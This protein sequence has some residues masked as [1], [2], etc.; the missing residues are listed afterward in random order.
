[1]VS[2]IGR[3]AIG[4]VLVILF[5]GATVLPAVGTLK[6]N[7]PAEEKF[8]SYDKYNEIVPGEFIVKF[9][10]KGMVDSPAISALNEEHQVYSVKKI[11]KNAEDTILEHLYVLKV[12]KDSD[13]VSIVDDYS[14]CPDVV[15]AEPSVKV[16][17]C[18]IP[19]D[20]NFPYQWPLNNSGQFL[21]ISDCDIDA[22]EAWNIEKGKPNIVIASID[23]G[24][25]YHHEDIWENIWTNDDEI[26]GN[27]IDDDYNGY[28]DDIVGWDFCDNDSDP[29]DET[30]NPQFGHGTRCA[31]L[32][33]AITNNSIGIAGV[34]WYCKTMVVRCWATGYDVVK[35]A[36]GIVYAADN[37]ADVINIEMGMTY[38]SQL[39]ED[40][41]NYAYS[42]GCFL[43]ACAG[44]YNT[45][46]CYYPAAF[47]NVTAVA[48]TN[49]RDERC[50]EDDWGT[51]HGSNYGDW[52][53][54]AAPG[55][56]IFTLNPNDE[57]V[58]FNQGGTSLTAPFVAGLAALLL[59][60]KP[61][62]TPDELH[63]IICDE[64]NVDPYNSTEY[65]GTGRINA[66][67]ALKS[68]YGYPELE[69]TSISGG[70]GV[71]ANVKNTGDNEAIDVNT[72]I[73]V[74][75]GILKQINKIFWDTASLLVVDD[76]HTVKTDLFFG[77]GKISVTV[78]SECFEGQSCMVVREG[79]QILFL[80]I[81]LK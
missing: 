31:G 51:G 58:F 50:D 49:Q 63:A 64:R 48:A 23:S 16:E 32:H 11:F 9:S 81:L 69:I 77:L 76:E 21:G 44:N 67:K 68:L 62:L 80:T 74:T 24:V 75:G 55:N 25:D 38:N 3:K 53:D 10:E 19:N 37:G 35:Y 22:P 72:S 29:N 60:H 6:E 36:Q 40:A 45:T 1:M 13:I 39:L 57:Y 78:C 26:P 8:C 79:I 66:Y 12:P 30:V 42:N 43:C 56:S 46:T 33:S 73:T 18:E 52:I 47:D 5:I 61:D 34:G 54:V 71:T 70:L 65:I 17:L 15:Y 14:S 41:V 28:V 2:H 20:E 7:E 59:S 27:D 4:I